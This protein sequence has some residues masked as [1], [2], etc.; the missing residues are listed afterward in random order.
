MLITDQV[1][2]AR[3]ID[4]VQAQRPTLEAKSGRANVLRRPPVLIV[5]QLIIE[6]S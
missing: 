6:V 1:A 2:T 4:C 3:C 5:L